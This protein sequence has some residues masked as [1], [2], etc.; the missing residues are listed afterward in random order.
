MVASCP[1][2]EDQATPISYK[3]ENQIPKQRLSP[4]GTSNPTSAR[5]GGGDEIGDFGDN[6]VGCLSGQCPSLLAIKAVQ[7]FSLS[8]DQIKVAPWMKAVILAT[9]LPAISPAIAH[10]Y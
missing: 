8:P 10:L 9:I 2:G 6:F 7:S 3:V 5:D 1:H 4:F